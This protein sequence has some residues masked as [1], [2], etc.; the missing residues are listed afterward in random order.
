MSRRGRTTAR[1]RLGHRAAAPKPVQ[2]ALPLGGLLQLSRLRAPCKWR[3]RLPRAGGVCWFPSRGVPPRC[4]YSLGVLDWTAQLG[5]RPCWSQE[6]GRAQALQGVR[7]G[8]GAAAGRLHGRRVTAASRSLA[9][10]QLVG[11]R[12]GPRSVPD[13][14]NA[15]ATAAAGAARAHPGDRESGSLSEVTPRVLA[16]RPGGAYADLSIG[17]PS[18]RARSS[19]RA[20]VSRHILRRSQLRECASAP[21]ASA[22]S[23]QP[24]QRA[25]E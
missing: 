2:L 13:P 9:K 16:G 5:V 4:G 12:V 8:A 3:T 17:G 21:A 22:E 7:Q 18:Q 20:G 10:E 6:R 23:L 1:E 19:S 15:A 25:Y 14:W 11:R 24:E